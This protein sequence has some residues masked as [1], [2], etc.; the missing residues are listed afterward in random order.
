[1][2]TRE[3]AAFGAT[4][5]RLRCHLWA[6]SAPPLGRL[7]RPFGQQPPSAAVKEKKKIWGAPGAPN[8]FFLFLSP[9]PKAVVS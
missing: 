1:M 5:G 4:F 7:R 3:T 9:P 8:L 6:P 2:Y